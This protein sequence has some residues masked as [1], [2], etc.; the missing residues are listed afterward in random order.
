MNI[1]NPFFYCDL[2]CLCGKGVPYPLV[3]TSR[4]TITKSENER[5]H[6]SL[7]LG[8]LTP[9]V[10]LEECLDTQS[11]TGTQKPLLYKKLGYVN[12]LFPWIEHFLREIRNSRRH[13]PSLLPRDAGARTSRQP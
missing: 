3:A 13:V 8:D 1:G 2:D 6:V 10:L 4:P 5:R 11:L 9:R 12:A 7:D